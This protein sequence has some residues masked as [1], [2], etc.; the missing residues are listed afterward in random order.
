MSSK[1]NRHNLDPKLVGFGILVV[2]A[3]LLVAAWLFNLGDIVTGAAMVLLVVAGLLLAG[4]GL[5][6]KSPPLGH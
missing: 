5:S 3:S 6:P 1:H 2:I 4:I